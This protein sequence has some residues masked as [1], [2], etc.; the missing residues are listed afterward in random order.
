MDPKKLFAGELPLQTET[1]F[2]ILMNVLDIYLTYLLL[3]NGAMEAN[4]M[5]NWVLQRWDFVG[6][7]VFKLIIVTAICIIAQLVATIR[8]ATARVLL[9]AGS[10]IVGAVVVYSVS[11]YLNN[12]Y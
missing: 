9:I 3:I 6:M 1:T 12:F 11:L 7:I 5:A 8:P 2:F 4:P 10:A